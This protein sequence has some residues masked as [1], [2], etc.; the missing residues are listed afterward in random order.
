MKTQKLAGAIALSG[1]SATSLYAAQPPNPT[2]VLNDGFYNVAMGPVALS[3]IAPAP[4]GGHCIPF[5]FNHA[6]PPFMAG[7]ANTATGFGALAQDATGYSNSALGAGALYSDTSGYY[8]TALGT[9]SMFRNTVGRGNSALGNLTLYSNTAG[10]YNMAL[11]NYALQSNTTG[12]SNSASGSSAM[13]NNLSGNYNTANGSY[14]LSYNL[15]GNSNTAA[16][17][18]AL[19]VSTNGSYNVA[20]GASALTNNYNVANKTSSS[21]N[22]AV[23]SLALGNNTTLLSG[24]Y[25]T[26]VGYY[27]LRNTSG[28][29]NTAVGSGALI[30]PVVSGTSSMSGVGNTALGNN[31]G[32]NLVTGSY[33]TYL[34]YG[35]P[36]TAGDNYV[37]TI[38][39]FSQPNGGPAYTPTTYIA[40]ISNSVITGATVVVSANGQLG[41]LASA[42]RYKTD[43]ASLGTTSEKLASLRPVSFHLKSE[44]NGTIQYGLIAE[45]VDKVYPE[46]VIH[47]KEGKIQGVRYDELAPMLLNEMQKQQATI[48][49]QTA[50]IHTLEAQSA[51]TQ[52]QLAEL[53]DLKKELNAAIRE[54][55][56]KDSLVAQR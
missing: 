56:S 22:V 21:F 19:D 1:L 31:A 18:Y 16:G 11:G 6:N 46:L 8:N 41:V 32:A 55:K 24:G 48:A 54:V 50:E 44:P 51:E 5:A 52:K 47:D 23:G 53:N 3:N 12:I 38:G 42:E 2:S 33:N 37:T 15:G 4:T 9:L 43:I 36:S 17:A 13:A 30:G 14:A 27:S 29:N 49:A 34:G 20:I 26:A 25:N 28:V 7:C 35:A 45:E 39:V 10:S 40:G